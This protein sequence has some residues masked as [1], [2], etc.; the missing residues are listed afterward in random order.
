MRISLAYLIYFVVFASSLGFSAIYAATSLQF[1]P[2]IIVIEHTS[3]ISCINCSVNGNTVNVLLKDNSTPPNP[4]TI[5]LTRVTGT[6]NFLSNPIKF[7]SL[8]P[9]LNQFPTAEGRTITASNTDGIDSVSII[10][11]RNFNLANV[12]SGYKVAKQP[13][14]ILVGVCSDTNS[15]TGGDDDGDGICNNWEDKSQFTAASCV[16]ADGSKKDGLCI[17][18]SDTSPVYFLPCDPKSDNWSNQCPDRKKTDLYYE[19]DF[20]TGHKPKKSAISD[21]AYAFRSSGYQPNSVSGVS[22]GINLHVQLDEN[23]THAT[24]ISS[25]GTLTNPGFDQLK[26][27]WFGTKDER[28][29]TSGVDNTYP[30][31]ANYASQWFKTSGLRDVKSQVFHYILFAHGLAGCTGSCSSGHSEMPGNDIVITLASFDNMIGTLDQQEGTIMHEIGHNIN[32]NHGG[33][34]IENCKPNYLS[35]MSY[36]RQFSDLVN[37]PLDYSNNTNLADINEPSL[38]S[39][40][41]SYGHTEQQIVFQKDS[42]A[43]GYWLTG[44]NLVPWG[45]NPNVNNIF[46]AGCNDNATPD[47]LKSFKDWDP[48]RLKLIARS[49]NGNWMD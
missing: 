47:I 36:S 42:T 13:V 32:L 19:I 7:T 41:G 6:N 28:G 4:T 33:N 24:Q 46:A 22:P 37:R 38:P 17:K 3:V 20:M 10:I 1:D 9:D 29:T 8:T 39:T 18:T 49:G 2:D 23:V 15:I 40:L 48:S 16:N 45:T 5:T 12:A 34:E 31:I 25:S 11:Q 44:S 30:T 43:L 26:V 14:S 35:V 27:Y 21:L